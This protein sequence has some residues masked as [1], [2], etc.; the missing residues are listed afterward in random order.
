MG[1]DYAV[2]KDAEC[3][4]LEKAQEAHHNFLNRRVIP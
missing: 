4:K 2:A 3:G 1:W